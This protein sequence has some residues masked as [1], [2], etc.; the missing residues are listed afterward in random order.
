MEIIKIEAHNTDYI[1]DIVNYETE[2][3]GDGSIGRWTIMPFVRYGKIYAMI[4]NNE[5]IS[6]VELMKA[7]DNE[8]VYIYGFFT[9]EKYSGNGYGS[10]L[11]KFTI[12]EMRKNKVKVLSLTVD[13]ENETAKNLYLKH[14]FKEAGLLED[15]YGEGVHRL[16]L[17]L[18]LDKQKQK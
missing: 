12:N 5:V 1:T 9:K 11:L 8:E 18:F 4:D 17:K 16:Y 3:F 6:A 10:E 15:E 7:F 2:I 13:P 14:G